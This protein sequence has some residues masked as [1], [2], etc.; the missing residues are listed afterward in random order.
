MQ[1]E[2]LEMAEVL[3]ERCE[4][5]GGRGEVHGGR[6]EVQGEVC[7]VQGGRGEV[8]EE[9]YQR[10]PGLLLV[11]TAFRHFS[12]ACEVWEHLLHH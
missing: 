2:H 9:P 8:R 12:L 3:G 10:F 7:E 1:Q 5:Q 11:D 4:V 6:R